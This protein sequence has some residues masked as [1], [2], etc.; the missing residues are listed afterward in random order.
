MLERCG[1]IRTEQISFERVLTG[2]NVGVF[3]DLVPIYIQIGTDIELNACISI[4]ETNRYA[5]AV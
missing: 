4:S 3:L 1:C 2:S 5:C